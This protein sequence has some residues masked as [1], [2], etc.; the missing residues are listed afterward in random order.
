[1]ITAHYLHV[2]FCL[3]YHV[4]HFL[5]DHEIIDAPS[6]VPFSRARDLIP[7]SILTRFLV[8]FSE[9]IYVAHVDNFID[10]CTFLRQ[11]ARYLRIGSRPRQ[12]NFLMCGVVVTDNNYIFLF[13][14]PLLCP[15]E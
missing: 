14:P 2:I 11:E 9:N 12:V 10:P 13:L 1:M 8:V 3:C 5:T 7:I 6:G 15:V 4:T